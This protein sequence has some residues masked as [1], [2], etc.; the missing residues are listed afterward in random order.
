LAELE[1]VRRSFSNYQ[2]RLEELHTNLEQSSRNFYQQARRDA[3]TGAYNR[4]AIEEDW[5]A[6]DRGEH[7]RQCAFLLFDCDHFKAIN[8]SYGHDVGDAVIKAVASCLE[9]ALRTSDRLYRLGG[10]EFATFLAD[11]NKEQTQRISERCLELVQAH[12]FQQYGLPEPVGISIGVAMI[13]N[14]DATRSLSK[15]Q[16]QADLAMYAA[17]RPGGDKI[18]VY[19]AELGEVASLVASKSIQAVFSAIKDPLLL[20]MHYQGIIKLPEQ[21]P[22]YVEALARITFNGELFGPGD[23]FPIV[24]SRR[25]DAEFDLAI[26]AAVRRDLE[27]G[28]LA[29]DQGVSIN[30]SAP[31]IVQSNIVDALLELSHTQQRK[32]VIE[33]TETTLITQ[34]KTA[35]RHIRQLREAGCLVALD[36]FGSG[37]SS[38]RYLSSMPVDIVKFDI[39][40]IRLLNAESPQQRVITEEM[41]AIVKT[42]G[43]QIV[44]EGI[45]TEQM[46]ESVQRIGFHY[47]QGFLFGKPVRY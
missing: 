37:Y 35:S 7:H 32:I 45:E 19:R 28:V 43:Y 2:D 30:I 26:I 20:T 14:Q 22:D 16:K 47:A 24:Q 42:A 34:M 38:L 39:S 33:I 10:D 31:G 21:S 5:S 12:D 9:Q 13:N 44:A 41:A 11:T 27:Q 8:D 25:L 4:R 15:L 18:V 6:S 1:N 40:M 17:K 36:D 3:L 29:A 46:L 23:I